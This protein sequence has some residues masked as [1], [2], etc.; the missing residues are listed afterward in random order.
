[1]NMEQTALERLLGSLAQPAFYEKDGKV[2]F[3][4]RLAGECR[5]RIG[6]DVTQL[7][8]DGAKLPSGGDPVQAELALP[9]GQTAAAIVPY[10]DGRLYLLTPPDRVQLQPQALLA[11]AQSIRTPLSNLFGVAAALFPRL[12]TLEDPELQEQTAA[13]NRAYY[14]LLRLT[15]NLTD[16][17]S[18]LLG[19]LRLRREKEELTGFFRKLF[20]RA[21]PLIRAAGRELVYTCS[22]KPFCG[23]IDRQRLERAVWDVLSNALKFTA[24]GGVITAELEYTHTTAI[25]RV[26]DDGDGLTA[27]ELS[28]AFSAFDRDFALGDPRWGAGFGLPLAEHIARL[29]GGALLLESGGETGTTVTLSLSLQVPGTKEL[30]FRSPTAT[31][32]YTGG[33]PHE[34]VELSNVLPLSE[35]DSSRI[36]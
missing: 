15:C 16:M 12:E 34:L 7:L 8:P 4:N 6:H 20:D 11:I 13:M 30:Q 17:R 25:L 27:E 9:G 19:E 33:Y 3:C 1:M 18:A 22:A 24:K 2:L 21:S 5:V 35:F 23:W 32:D 31:I 14:Q 28:T 10:L 36:N 29:H 26:H